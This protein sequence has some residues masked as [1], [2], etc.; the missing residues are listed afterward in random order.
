MN[1]LTHTLKNNLQVISSLFELQLMEAW[2]PETRA[3]LAESFSR[4]SVIVIIHQQLSVQKNLDSLDVGQVVE[5]VFRKSIITHEN[6]RPAI[7]YTVNVSGLAMK[8]D[9][10]TC[11]G[12][13]INE[14]LLLSLRDAQPAEPRK[15]TV[16]SGSESHQSFIRYN[17]SALRLNKDFSLNDPSLPLGLRLINGLARQL[18]GRVDFESGEGS[19]FRLFFQPAATS[20][21]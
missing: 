17:D 3:A 14:L 2:E 5:E 18:G 16:D 19:I 7:S 11:L 8:I 20:K 9:Q 12:L 4:F 15:I 6:S 21:L 13:I 1:E 10:A